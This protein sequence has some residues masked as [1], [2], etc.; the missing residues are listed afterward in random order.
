[1]HHTG[2]CDE[3]LIFTVVVL[4]RRQAMDAAYYRTVLATDGTLCG[5]GFS[6][7]VMAAVAIIF[8]QLQP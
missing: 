4:T 1:M 3:S 6:K 2:S 7:G 8:E 5:T